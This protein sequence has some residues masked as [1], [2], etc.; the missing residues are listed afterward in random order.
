MWK[1]KNKK[2]KKIKIT[3][4]FYKRE[5]ESIVECIQC[6]LINAPLNIRVVWCL[7]AKFISFYELNY[8]FFMSSENCK[9]YR[10]YL[11]TASNVIFLP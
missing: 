7:F 3:T 2:N 11:N 4:Y 9:E 1:R 6:V 8:C 10:E 5:I